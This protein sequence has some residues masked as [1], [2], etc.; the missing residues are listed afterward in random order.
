MDGIRAGV[1]PGLPVNWHTTEPGGTPH[2]DRRVGLPAVVAPLF[3]V[4]LMRNN[5]GLHSL[6]AG[7]LAQSEWGNS[8]IEFPHV[9]E[10]TAARRWTASSVKTMNIHRV[11]PAKSAK[12]EY[13]TIVLE[14]RQV[15][16]AISSLLA[17]DLSRGHDHPSIPLALSSLR[18]QLRK[19]DAQAA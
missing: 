12:N 15:E 4:E 9:R 10:D 16:A 11:R 7:G 1:G 19:Y 5:G 2:G 13:V 8:T 18:S 6:R 14:R 3:F 17:L